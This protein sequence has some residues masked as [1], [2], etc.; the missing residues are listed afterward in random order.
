MMQ[1]LERIIALSAGAE[2]EAIGE[3][4][5]KERPR[6]PVRVRRD[7]P[8]GGRLGA[9]GNVRQGCDQCLGDGGCLAVKGMARGPWKFATACWSWPRRVRTEVLQVRQSAT[10]LRLRTI[11]R[12]LS[13]LPC[14]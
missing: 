12:R 1:H 8:L 5:A 6:L 9:P 2:T 10:T 11:V 7:G 13:S 3:A 14:P 4:A